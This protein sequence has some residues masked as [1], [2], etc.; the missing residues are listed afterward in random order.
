MNRLNIGLT[1]GIAS[2]KSK[3]ATFFEELG[4][5]TIDADILSREI[6]NIGEK[7]YID[8]VNYFGKGILFENGEINRKALRNIIFNNKEKRLILES[9]THPEIWKKEEK[10]KKNI[11][12]KDSKALIITHAALLIET[13]SY[14]KFNPLIFVYTSIDNQIKRLMERDKISEKEANLIINNQMP[15]EEK[16]KYPHIIID[17][18]SDENYLKKEVNRVANLIKQIYY[19]INH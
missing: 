13:G 2:G 5:Y 16:L 6:F 9:I 17:N 10:Y 1:G 15:L 11:Y 19:G 18:N 3:T 8:T 7:A 14:K 4:F 12:S